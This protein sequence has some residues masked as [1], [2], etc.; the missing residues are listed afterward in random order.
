MGLLELKSQ[1][2]LDERILQILDPGHDTWVLGGLFREIRELN[3]NFFPEPVF[4]EP[5]WRYSLKPLILENTWRTIKKTNNILFSSM[6]PL[7]NYLNLRIPGDRS[8]SL[9]FTHKES[10]FT[11]AEISALL[12]LN[13]IYVHST[14]IR[15]LLNSVLNGKVRIKVVIGG[16]L[17]ARFHRV[18][19]QGK[20]VIWAGTS[21]ERKRPNSLLNIIKNC[22]EL[23]FRILGKGWRE[24]FFWE[25]INNLPNVEY[26][27][28]DTPLTVENFDD[29]YLFLSISHTEGGPMTLLEAMASGVPTLVTNTG[30]AQDLHSLNSK[31][32]RI[33]DDFSE[34]S[35]IYELRTAMTEGLKNSEAI[36][37]S[38]KH[39]TIYKLSEIL[40]E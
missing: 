39:L 31:F 3:P 34:M 11:S 19:K 13:V 22:P 30:F 12:K 29:A 26:C 35:T 2:A 25:A 4:L 10:E 33:I 5:V 21:V 24:S 7:I 27:E 16:V 8:L 40:S 28:I 1:K 6:T 32:P 14:Q 36:R 15:D 20:K 9:W 23:E 37:E 38:V 18:A 17:P